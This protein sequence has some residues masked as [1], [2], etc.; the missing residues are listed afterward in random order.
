MMYFN[1]QIVG[2][3]VHNVK[4]LFVLTRWFES[5]CNPV[6]FGNIVRYIGKHDSKIIKKTVLK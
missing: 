6:V 3:F 1:F 2:C 5:W 4:K